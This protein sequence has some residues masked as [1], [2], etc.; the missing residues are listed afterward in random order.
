MQF[1]RSAAD[2]DDRFRIG[3]GCVGPLAA[4]GLPQANRRFL[5]CQTTDKN[6]AQIVN[7]RTR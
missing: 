5:T 3:I 6:T 7:W 2:D 1:E 4:A